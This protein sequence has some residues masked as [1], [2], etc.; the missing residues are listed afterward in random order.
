MKY[1]RGE[2]L[3]ERNCCTSGLCVDCHGGPDRLK[4]SGKR[5]TRV[6]QGSG[7]SEAYAKFVASNWSAYKAEARPS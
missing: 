7:Y 2:W 1:E 6:V 4:L 3:V 5:P